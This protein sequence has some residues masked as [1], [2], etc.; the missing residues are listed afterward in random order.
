MILSSSSCE[1]FGSLVAVR[2]YSCVLLLEVRCLCFEVR[3]N[4]A[5]ISCNVKRRLLAYNTRDKARYGELKMYHY[6]IH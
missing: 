6:G 2:F 3:Y 4:L 5:A 1:S